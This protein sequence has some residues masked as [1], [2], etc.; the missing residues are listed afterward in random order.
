MS[1]L[2]KYE[3]INNSN[4]SL[5]YK[6]PDGTQFSV[7]GKGK[8]LVTLDSTS[9]VSTRVWF[10]K[11][12][13]IV[14]NL[15]DLIKLTREINYQL[16]GISVYTYDIINPEVE[17][18]VED[19]DQL[20]LDLET[21]DEKP[22]EFK[23]IWIDK[24]VPV[25]KTGENQKILVGKEGIPSYKG[26][27]ITSSDVSVAEIKGNRVNAL[28]PGDVIITVKLAGLEST[29]KLQVVDEVPSVE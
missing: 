7:A 16:S 1:N 6:G 18:K 26:L 13:K 14:Y 22:T 9:P 24:F 28:R 27:L 25:M 10:A 29:V 8:I 4:K 17:T 19:K 2:F 15:N 3:F 20:E 23:R 5:S 12:K 11:S 21:D